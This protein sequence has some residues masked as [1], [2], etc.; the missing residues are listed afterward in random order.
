MP[1]ILE[2]A[3]NAVGGGRQE[4]YGHPYVCHS[5]TAALWSAYLGIEISPE[6]VCWLNILQKA[7]RNQNRPTEDNIVD[8]AGYAYCIELIREYEEDKHNAE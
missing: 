2:Q 4:D 3:A 1:T 7:A 5:R 6:M 8:T